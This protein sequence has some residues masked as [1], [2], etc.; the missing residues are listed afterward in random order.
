MKTLRLTWRHAS[1]SPLAALA[2]FVAAC[3]NDNNPAKPVGPQFSASF[4]GYSN[5]DTKQTACGNC[6]VQ[7]QNSWAK[8][9]HAKAWGDVQATGSASESCSQCHTL[10]GKANIGVDTGGYYAAAANAKQSFQDVQCESCHGPGEAHVTVPDSTQ[11]IPYFASL[12]STVDGGPVGCGTCHSGSHDP[13]YENWQVGMHDTLWAPA[14]SN[15]TPG[16]AT[17]LACRQCHEGREAA[18]RW[19][20]T[21]VYVEA[22]SSTAMPIG[23]TTC[24][25][26]H[27]TNNEKE[28]RASIST[29]DTL[30]LCIQCHKR[31]SVPDVTST[32]GPHAPQGPTF[33]GLSGWR[34]AGFTW[35]ANNIP[36]HADPAS[37]PRLCATC[38]V[39]NWSM[40]SGATFYASTGH[41]FFAIPCV[42]ADGKIIQTRTTNNTCDVSQRRFAAC[43]T[44]G[45]HASEGAARAM[46]ESTEA[47]LQ[48]LADVIWKDVNG[49]DKVDAGDTGLLMSVPST[50]FKTRTSATTTPYTV[51][52]GAQFNKRML[53][54]DGS[55]GVHN[56][57]YMRA[58]LIASINAAKSTYALP[59]APA[60]QARLDAIQAR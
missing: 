44:S 27:G 22:T 21:K 19:D 49:N 43:A 9:G 3:T 16:T 54:T 58:L 50:E 13:F 40:G 4:V 24:H 60:L 17:V 5:P 59:V 46:F 23:C 57:P 36:T 28:L 53:A 42:D 51:A 14:I 38:H 18:A 11:P 37:N 39:E 25:D 10:N 33:L 56:P 8:T 6:H 32:R 2:L 12:D 55:N 15:T 26:P 29:H 20:P 45:C 31:R 30:N 1:L 47:D 7:K 35:D 41:Q 48:F 34:P 52:E